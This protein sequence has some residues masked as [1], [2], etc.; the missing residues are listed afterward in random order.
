[1]QASLMAKQS[2]AARP[3]PRMAKQ[4]AKM[5]RA[6]GMAE[7]LPASTRRAAYLVACLLWA[8]TALQAHNPTQATY[9]LSYHAAKSTEP[10]FWKLN[11]NF[12]QA[13]LHAAVSERYGRERVAALSKPDYEKLVVEYIKGNLSILASGAS[14]NVRVPIEPIGVLL[15]SHASLISFRLQGMPADARAVTMVSSIGQENQGQENVLYVILAGARTRY[16]MRADNQWQTVAALVPAEPQPTSVAPWIAIVSGMGLL[17]FLGMAIVLW[18][19]LIPLAA[20][21]Q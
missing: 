15:G 3:R 9:F 8:G 20:G 7:G 10:A 11:M 5:R 1:M 4:S 21:F 17:M 16:V 19:R 12:G 18:R 6:I 14:A 2:V 13:G